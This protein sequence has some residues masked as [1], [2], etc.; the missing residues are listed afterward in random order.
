MKIRRKESALGT[1]QSRRERRSRPLRWAF[2]LG[3]LAV[4]CQRNLP[5]S[6]LAPA[7]PHAEHIERLWW[8]MLI[9]YGIVFVITLALLAM[10]LLARKRDESVLGS[11]FVFVAGIAIPAVILV[12][13]LI[14]DLRV[15]RAIS[16][17]REDL[18]VQVIGHGWWFEVRYPEYGIVDAN[19]IHVPAGGM[20]RFEL[21][22][23]SMA[24][25]F[26]VPRLG[27]K[28]DQLPDHPNELRLEASQPG[29]YHGF[30]TEYCAGPHARMAFRLVAHEPARFERWLAQRQQ[31]VSEPADPR[32]LRGKE[33]YLRSGCASCHAI[34]GV[35]E[36]AIGPDL[37]LVGSRLTLGAGQ[38]ENCKGVLAGWIADPQ[39]LKPGNLMPAS[40]LSPEDLHSMV[41]Y[42]LGLNHDS[43]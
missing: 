16:S 43:Q 15:G 42:L 37:T 14:A 28:R 3:T 34:R 8:Q 2:L 25:S 7:G 30:C 18:H 38:F 26:W 19:E 10:A 6:I 36:G 13:M 17:D 41:D 4:G 33:A 27:G 22:S 1:C 29:V 39:A 24:H 20:V 11:R 40:Y 9:V 12:I 5:A 31:P 23:A 21:S 32:L 35:S